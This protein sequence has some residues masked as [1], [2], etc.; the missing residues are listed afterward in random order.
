M[1]VSK[2]KDCRW[3]LCPRIGDEFPWTLHRRRDSV[4]ARFRAERLFLFVLTPLS[5]TLL[6]LL[7]GEL[8]PEAREN[9]WR[10]RGFLSEELL[11]LNFSPPVGSPTNF[12]V[13]LRSDDLEVG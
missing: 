7:V 8:A 9:A 12:V 6:F 4:L 3:S 13:V 11:P 5:D 1:L 10:A 2:T